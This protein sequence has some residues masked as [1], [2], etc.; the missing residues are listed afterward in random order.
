MGMLGFAGEVSLRGRRDVVRMILPRG[1]S[2]GEFFKRFAIPLFRSDIVRQLR[3]YVFEPPWGGMV[4]LKPRN[5]LFGATGP[6]FG[7][8]Y[9]AAWLGGSGSITKIGETT[10]AFGISGARFPWAG[11]QRGSWF[12]I[13]PADIGR[14]IVIRST[15]PRRPWKRVAGREHHP[16]KWALWWALGGKTGVFVSGET[17]ATRGLRVPVRPHAAPNPRIVRRIADRWAGEVEEGRRR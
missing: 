12:A 5:P 15:T 2:P 1:E 7:T 14:E 9:Q 17:L 3:A 16:Q 8:A 6:L 10:A 13:Q 11:I 4:R